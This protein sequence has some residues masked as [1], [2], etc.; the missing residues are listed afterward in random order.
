M[1]KEVQQCISKG[2]EED[3]SEGGNMDVNDVAF[4][5]FLKPFMRKEVHSTCL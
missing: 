4:E 5:I 3:E 1:L 2:K